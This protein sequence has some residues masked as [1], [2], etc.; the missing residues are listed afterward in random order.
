MAVALACKLPSVGFERTRHF[1]YKVLRD[2][3]SW[4]HSQLSDCR[5]SSSE[6]PR[7]GLFLCHKTYETSANCGIISV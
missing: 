4:L 5:Q 7:F 1:V 3:K 6:R 2:K